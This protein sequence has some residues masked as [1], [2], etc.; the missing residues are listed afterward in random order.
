[1]AWNSTLQRRWLGAVVVEKVCQKLSD[2]MDL[3]C[4]ACIDQETIP[5]EDATCVRTAADDFAAEEQ[6]LFADHDET[7]RGTELWD[8]TKKVRGPQ[9]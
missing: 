4:D 9:P 5:V 3:H 2:H 7:A 6:A 1:M 8:A